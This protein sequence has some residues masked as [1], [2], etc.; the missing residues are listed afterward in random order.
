M[1]NPF[2]TGKEKGSPS[3]GKHS[4]ENQPK[5]HGVNGIKHG[6]FSPKNSWDVPQDEQQHEHEPTPP[7]SNSFEEAE[8]KDL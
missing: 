6:S 5:E 7:I 4:E 2:K 3:T 8:E 1:F